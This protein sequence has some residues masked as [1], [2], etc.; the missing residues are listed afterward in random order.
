M[1]KELRK[2]IEKRNKIAADMR[3]MH[4]AAE[5]DD[6]GFTPE[7]RQKWDS[8]TKDLDG[9]ELRIESAKKLDEMRQ[10]EEAPVNDLPSENRSGRQSQEENAQA[11]YEDAFR[12]LIRSG[13]EGLAGL[14]AEHRQLLVERRAQTT[15]A[16]AGGY[17]VA[18]D[19]GNRIV[20][21]MLQFGG[22]MN[23][24]TIITTDGGNALPFPTNDDT[25]NTGEL[26]TSETTA[27]TEQDTTFDQVQLDAYFFSS[28]IIRVS[29]ALL[30][31]T[32]F[33]L[34][35]YLPK[36]LGERIGRIAATYLATGTG[37]SQPQ[38]IVTGAGTGV[39]AGGASV[40]A[41]ADF[42]GLEHSIDPAY[43]I[44]N[45]SC[46]YVFNDQTLKA[47]RGLLDGDS[48]P[49]WQPALSGLGAGVPATLNGYRY[50]IDQGVAN[51][52][53]GNVSMV[54]GD[55]SEFYVRMVKGITLARLVERYA[56]YF[57][58]GF[59]SHARIDSVVMNSAAIK[60]LTHP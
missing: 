6:R 43:R 39:T 31:D 42:L 22:V 1:T 40:I 34:D 53:T 47:A 41:Y 46:G 8:M 26:V 59:V 17:T 32:A 24:A 54:F 10:F 11:T 58:V 20:E 21:S 33:N 13:E 14:S 9:L 23:A 27:A 57:Q 18:E 28:K 5:D 37:S 38:G 25:G 15:T 56:E 48:R 4:K 2:L 36:K 60:K 19:F 49:L 29:L 16:A 35:A 3:A 51:I 50:T 30:Q 44:N 12:A 7:E 52:G 45:P 55:I